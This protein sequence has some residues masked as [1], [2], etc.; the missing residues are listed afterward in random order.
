MNHKVRR[1]FFE[2]EFDLLFDF[3]ELYFF[4]LEL[5]QIFHDSTLVIIINGVAEPEFDKPVKFVREDS[6]NLVNLGTATLFLFLLTLHANKFVLC[7][8]YYQYFTEKTTLSS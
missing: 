5:V 1:L 2:C 7:I 6:L 4:A 3:S 8:Y